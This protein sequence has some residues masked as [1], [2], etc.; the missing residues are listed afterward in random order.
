MSKFVNIHTH[1]PDS[2]NNISVKNTYFFTELE[3]QNENLF[4]SIGLHP[5]DIEKYEFNVF[6]DSLKRALNQKKL[7]FVGEIGIDRAISTDISLQK[8]IF[9]KQLLLAEKNSVPVIIHCV[10]AY[11]DILQILRKHKPTVALIFHDFRA[12]ETIYEQLNRYNS[13]FSFGKVLFSRTG[14][15]LSYFSNI[16]LSRKFFET[17]D[18]DISIEKIYKQAAGLRKMDLEALKSQIFNNFENLIFK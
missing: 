16:P 9:E 15:V 13:Y 18:A 4:L 7:R 6:F 11:S 8:T 1:N 5:W 12:N 17:D 14:K 10:R 3:T 2:G